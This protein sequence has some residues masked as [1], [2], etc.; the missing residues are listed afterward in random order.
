LD[1]MKKLY[2]TW[3]DVKIH[4]KINMKPDTKEPEYDIAA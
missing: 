4:K 1:I 2:T 3:P